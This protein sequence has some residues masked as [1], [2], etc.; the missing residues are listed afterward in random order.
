[1][2]I[3]DFPI[4]YFFL[5][6]VLSF[7][8]LF[9]FIYDQKH[10]FHYLNVVNNWKIHEAIFSRNHSPCFVIQMNLQKLYFSSQM[11]TLQEARRN[12]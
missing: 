4:N 10:V 7:I 3:L 12:V 1:M 6:V 8:L 5:F 2:I 9:K 11:H